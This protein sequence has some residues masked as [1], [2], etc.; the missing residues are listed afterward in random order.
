MMMWRHV[1][2]C[3]GDCAS[4]SCSDWTCATR[5]AFCYKGASTPL[6]ITGTAIDANH[7]GG[8]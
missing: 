1:W 4:L 3:V 6:R 7:N 5:N 8:C 2:A